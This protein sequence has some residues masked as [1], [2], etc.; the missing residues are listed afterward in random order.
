MDWRALGKQ[1]T[2]AAP[3]LGG[4]LGGPAGAAVGGLIAHAFGTEPEPDAIA[5][6]IAADPEAAVK[7]REIELRHA[8]TLA[9]L[10]TADVQY[11]REAHAR[12]AMPAIITLLLAVMVVGAFA[13][14]VLAEIPAGSREAA[15]LIVGQVIGAFASAVAYWIGSSRGSVLKQGAIERKA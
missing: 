15:L 13:T 12:S 7:L 10:I 5:R 6:A 8:E 2:R 14:L 1:I 4:A 3:A 11:A 9:A